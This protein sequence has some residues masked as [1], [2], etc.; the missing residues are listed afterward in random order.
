M[1]CDRAITLLATGGPLDRWRAR[2]HASRCARCAADAGSLQKIARELAAVEPLSAAQRALWSSVST[3]PR[4][5]ARPVG[6]LPA[7]LAG[8]VAAAVL[9]VGIGVTILT[10]RPAPQ[11]VPP[12]PVPGPSVVRSPDVARPVSPAVIRELDELRSN[13][14]ALSHELAQLRR[15]AELLDE[16][17]DADALARRFERSVAFNLP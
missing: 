15:R 17:R 5:V 4:P 8:A 9:A 6:S 13:F 14:R 1:R 10:R 11:P 12:T 16:R 2:R 3:E 7:L